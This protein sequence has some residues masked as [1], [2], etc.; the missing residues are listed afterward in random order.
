MG[1]GLLVHHINRPRL[2]DL[3]TNCKYKDKFHTE[4]NFLAERQMGLF[5]LE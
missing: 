4:V 5:S 2:G 3:F 1:V